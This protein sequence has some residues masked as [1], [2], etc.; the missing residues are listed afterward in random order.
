MAY[1][2]MD[3]GSALTPIEHCR[4]IFKSY[5]QQIAFK[6]GFG[7]PGSNAML[8]L[9]DTLQGNPGDTIRYHFIPQND[10][11][12]IEGQNAAVSGNE[13]ELAEYYMDVGVDMIRKAFRKHGK[14]TDHRIIWKFRNEVKQQSTNWWAQRSDRWLMWALTGWVNGMTST[15]SGAT[16]L[17]TTTEVASAT[18]TTD[19]VTGAGRCIRASGAAASAEVTAANSDNTA[20]YAAMTNA[21]KISIRLL[22][23]AA[24]MAKTSGTYKIR[25]LKVGPNGEEYFKLMVHT[26]VARDLRQTPEWQSRALSVAQAG[27]EGDPLATGAMGVWAPNIIVQETERIVTFGVAATK[28][29]ARN[30]LLGANAGLLAWVQKLD[31]NEELLDAGNI[32]RMVTDE[33]RGQRKFV[34]NGVDVGVAQ[35][36]TACN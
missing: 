1:F 28:V 35:V 29:L 16:A 21:D 24:I 7:K 36:I 17:P 30:L 12:G 32:F 3:T 23:D 2:I 14:M 34:F 19:L 13:D 4:T 18:A 10:T 6:G 15:A 33:I 8:I 11:E 25:P 26:K 9:D 27:L 31:W 5:L 22:E 20:L